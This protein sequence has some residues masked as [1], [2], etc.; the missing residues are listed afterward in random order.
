MR[1]VTKQARSGL[2]VEGLSRNR[3]SRNSMSGKG[4]SRNRLRR[5]GE[6]WG[7]RRRYVMVSR[8]TLITVGLTRRVGRR[9]RFGRF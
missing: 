7:F 9:I 4:S 8:R 6:E 3:L 2:G 1:P 5:I